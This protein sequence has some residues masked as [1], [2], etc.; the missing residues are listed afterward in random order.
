[1]AANAGAKAPRIGTQ[2]WNRSMNP[3]PMQA[4]KSA[5]ARIK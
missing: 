5:K 3:S 1:M 2:K 4:Q